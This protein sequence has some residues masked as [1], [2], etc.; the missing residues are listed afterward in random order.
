LAERRAMVDN[1]NSSLSI[2]QQCKIL[3]IH[4]SGLYYKPCSESDENLT[5]LRLLDEQYFKTP[6][7]GVRKLTVLLNQQGFTINRKRVKRLMELMG[8]QTLYRYKS[9]SKPD[10]QN[11][12]YP[13]LLK[14]LKVTRAN[15][16]WAMDITYVP[17]RKGFMYLCAVIDL[18]TRYVVNWSLSNTMTA[19]WCK[20][21]A[22]EAMESH[23][24]P[25]IFNTDQGSQFTSE[26]FTGLMKERNI[27]ISMDGKGRAIDNI[28]IERLWRTIK[29]EYVYLHAVE[30]GVQLYDGLNKYFS[31]YNHQRPHQ[32]LEYKTP[33]S[34]YLKM[35]AA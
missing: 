7:Y 1:Q 22:E 25:D 14:G 17:M 24:T 5:I 3:S 19:E 2:A 10:K 12:L 33:G 20:H 13:Y 31:F 30:D 21:V 27:Q 15:Q 6:F 34:C 11:R 8:W 9:T 28:F 26:V 4:R 23:G 29:Y 32:S 16:V 18:H 35:K